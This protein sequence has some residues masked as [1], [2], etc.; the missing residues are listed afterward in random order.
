MVE[1]GDRYEN[2]FCRISDGM[3]NLIGFAFVFTG[4]SISFLS[5]G[6][7]YKAIVSHQAECN[8]NAGKTNV[9]IKSESNLCSKFV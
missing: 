6:F 9:H 8:Q 5:T 2:G 1:D 3:T 4:S 7:R